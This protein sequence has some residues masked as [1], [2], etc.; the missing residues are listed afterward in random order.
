MDLCRRISRVVESLLDDSF[1]EVFQILL[2]LFF[3]IQLELKRKG[4]RRRFCTG[5]CDQGDRS[6][7]MRVDCSAV[8]VAGLCIK[9]SEELERAVYNLRVYSGCSSSRRARE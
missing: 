6:L 8:G 9:E 7:S 4:R 3:C 1:C 2:E 5:L